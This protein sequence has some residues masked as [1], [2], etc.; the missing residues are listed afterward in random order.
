[1]LTKSNH[2]FITNLC[3][4]LVVLATTAVANSGRV[5]GQTLTK[6]YIRLNGQVVAIENAGFPQ[7]SVNP[8]T[9]SFDPQP[10]AVTSAAHPVTVANSGSTAITLSIS[11]GGTN[12]PDFAYTT[13]CGSS[14]AAGARCTVSVTVTPTV[15]GADNALL[16]S[17][18][19]RQAR[20]LT[21]L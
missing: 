7:I 21:S 17:L 11:L 8:G 12:A 13:A 2:P 1:M 16:T 5:S 9:L 14:L 20:R 10:L 19:P 6:E 18:P 3:A 15:V 4:G